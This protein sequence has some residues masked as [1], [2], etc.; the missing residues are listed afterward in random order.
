MAKERKLTE[1][2]IKKYNR[3][4]RGKITGGTTSKK[5]GIT[6]TF[7]DPD[8]KATKKAKKLEEQ[9]AGL[10]GYKEP[11]KKKDGGEVNGKKKKPKGRSN[12]PPGIAINTG[13]RKLGKELTPEQK[14]RSKKVTNVAL[15]AVNPIGTAGARIARR[16]IDRAAI[17]GFTRAKQKKN[18]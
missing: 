13:F 15:G 10:I 14:R 17:K 6:F 16:S 3:K 8:E 2:E 5:D 7:V 11:V 1:E 9:E 4:N 18:A 12:L